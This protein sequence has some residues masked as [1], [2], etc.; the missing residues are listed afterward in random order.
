[1]EDDTSRPEFLHV[2]CRWTRGKRSSE[3]S[4][5]Q[6]RVRPD[7]CPGDKSNEIHYNEVKL[8]LVGQLSSL[9]L[10][11][12]ILPR[13]TTSSRVLILE[14]VA[15]KFASI[16][17]IIYIYNILRLKLRKFYR[18]IVNFNFDKS[19]K[20]TISRG[21]T[22]NINFNL[23]RFSSLVVYEEIFSFTIASTGS[24]LFC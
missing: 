3:R 14:Q 12:L 1:M 21:T 15:K 22:K 19:K 2:D 10:A 13:L 20:K 11:S 18:V 16:N 24:V 9:A 23:I 7:I 4:G 5:K 8:L 17:D 6:F